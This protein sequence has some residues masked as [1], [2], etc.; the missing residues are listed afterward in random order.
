ME[1]NGFDRQ[2]VENLKNSG[3]YFDETVDFIPELE[4]FPQNPDKDDDIIYINTAY[5]DRLYKR[6][7][8]IDGLREI[9]NTF[10]KNPE[11]HA[12]YQAR[13]PNLMKNAVKHGEFW[14]IEI[15]GG[16]GSGKSFF[17]RGYLVPMHGLMLRRNFNVH[18]NL[19]DI[20]DKFTV[21]MVDVLKR[22]LENERDPA[23]A[24]ALKKHI[25]N[26]LDNYN[27][28]EPFDVYVT[29]DI[30]QTNHVVKSYF[31]T[32]DI[33]FQDETPMMH[34]KGSTTSKD[35]IENILKVSPVRYNLTSHS[36]HLN[37]CRLIRCI[38]TSIF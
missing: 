31:K 12:Q 26:N 21:N 13:I 19:E 17:N 1:R 8:R 35:N 27:L 32:G 11:S 7:R 37:S 4:F 24:M 9:I 2:I 5:R 30:A 6:Y 16:P 18:F 3:R 22:R 29:Y 25:E 33:I 23:E 15:K 36:S 28:K 10:I 14:N 20:N 38:T 34:G